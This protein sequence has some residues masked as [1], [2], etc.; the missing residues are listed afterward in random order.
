MHYICRSIDPN[1]AHIYVDDECMIC[2]KLNPKH[3]HIY[4]NDKCILCGKIC[5]DYDNYNIFEKEYRKQNVIHKINLNDDMNK[6]IVRCP[7]SN[8]SNCNRT[9]CLNEK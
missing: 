5:G 3:K 6:P 2:H 7:E 1:H 4:K 8:C 9:K